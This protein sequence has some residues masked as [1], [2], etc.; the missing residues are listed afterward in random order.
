MPEP[1][2]KK[3]R[4]GSS[5]TVLGAGITGL[6]TAAE[7]AMRGYRVR[8][9]AKTLGWCPPLTISG[10]Q[11][12][13]Y[14]GMANCSEEY[15]K[16]DLLDKELVTMGRWLA[17]ASKP[18]ETGVT[19]IPALKCCRA[20]GKWWDSR[21]LDADRKRRAT[22]VQNSLRM[23]STP[24]QVDPA[25][26]EK[27]K[28]GG[29]KSVDERQ[30]VQLDTPLYFNYLMGVI[31]NH[32]GCICLGCDITKEF[33][34]SLKSHA[35]VNCLGLSSGV[36][37][38]AEGK[39]RS[40]PG[41]EVVFKESPGPMPFY[42]IDDDTNGALMQGKDGQL[43]VNSAAAPN[44]MP[45]SGVGGNAAALKATSDWKALERTL[46]AGGGETDG[47]AAKFSLA[48][49]VEAARK[50]IT[51]RDRVLNDVCNPARKS[52]PI[53][54]TLF[55][56]RENSGAAESGMMETARRLLGRPSGLEGLQSPINPGAD[57]A[58][59]QA[60]VDMAMIIDARLQ[61]SPHQCNYRAPDMGEDAGAALCATLKEVCGTE[62]TS[63]VVPN[64][65]VGYDEAC[66]VQSCKDVDDLCLALW[67]KKLDPA[68][69]CESWITDR[70]QRAEGF[71]LGAKRRE[72]GTIMVQNSGHGGVGITVSWA[73]AAIAADALLTA[74]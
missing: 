59:K 5:V 22:E 3:A 35:V 68:L 29:Y 16:Y 32:G 38:G 45:H 28:K 30:V 61:T 48:A 66:T 12:R 73:C 37:G 47:V 72:D 6:T 8:V 34:A 40:N 46:E 44:K 15:D 54:L 53:P 50:L 57:S 17:L 31:K 70:P 18:A 64:Q 25:V 60:W 33:I 27:L 42:V 52:Q 4:V 26:I 69:A 55:V 65:V 2:A 21:P 1:P 13:R 10:T 11:S 56:P 74:E 58:D 36:V 62:F 39:Y 71:N 14:P 41:E 49:R 9:I 43:V 20:E 23:A 63:R 24:K 67:G 7:L 19:V 51:N